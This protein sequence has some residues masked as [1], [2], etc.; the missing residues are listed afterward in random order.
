MEMNSFTNALRMVEVVIKNDPDAFKRS[1]F[2]TDSKQF[3][4]LE[5]IIKDIHRLETNLCQHNDVAATNRMADILVSLFKVMAAKGWDE[6]LVSVAMRV[7][8]R[9]RHGSV[10]EKIEEEINKRQSD[11]DN[12]RRLGILPDQIKPP[13]GLGFP[14]A[15][16]RGARLCAGKERMSHFYTINYG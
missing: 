9:A 6:A 14:W 2:L 8:M 10:F 3:T 13:T 1:N 11:W 16:K 15:G 4:V 5:H 7:A 12:Y